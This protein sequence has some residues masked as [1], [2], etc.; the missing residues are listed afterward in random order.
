MFSK[1]NG[2]AKNITLCIEI[3]TKQGTIARTLFCVT[4]SFFASRNEIS[5][6]YSEILALSTKN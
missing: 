6:N 3:G 5:K 2:F 4:I 1:S